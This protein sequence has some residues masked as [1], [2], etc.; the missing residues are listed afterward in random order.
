MRAH[1]NQ[2]IVPDVGGN[3]DVPD[4]LLRGVDAEGDTHGDHGPWVPGLATRGGRVGE[5]LGQD[6]GDLR[7]D[8]VLIRAFLQE[9]LT[10]TDISVIK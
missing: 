1:A 3:Q 9:S 7:L 5:P 2:L 10:L 4:F 6:T 8:Y